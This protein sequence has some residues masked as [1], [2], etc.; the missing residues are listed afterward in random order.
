MK[1]KHKEKQ[2]H[3]VKPKLDNY[4]S[5][6]NWEE[7]REYAEYQDRKK[8]NREYTDRLLTHFRFE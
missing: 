8:Q 1:Q 6:E 4:H 3:P 5:K 2:K 7:M